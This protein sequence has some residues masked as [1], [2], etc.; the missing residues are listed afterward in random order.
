[1]PKLPRVIKSVIGAISL[2]IIFE[3]LIFRIWSFIGFGIIAFVLTIGFFVWIEKKTILKRE[4]LIKIVLPLILL[5]STVAFIFFEANIYFIHLIIIFSSFCFYLFFSRLKFPLAK[6][7]SVIVTYYWLDLIAFLAAFLSYLFILNLL[8]VKDLPIWFLMIL[9]TLI[10]YLIFSYVLWARSKEGRIVPLFSSLFSLIL[11]ES[12]LAMSF[13]NIDPV[14]KSLL[15]VIVLYF[16]LGV[17]DLKLRG[18][19]TGRKIIEYL[20]TSIIAA[21]LVIITIR[22]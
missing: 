12:F 15:M 2:F 3:L 5:A 18:N 19:L 11:L 22:W 13:W 20:L 7:D 1:M 14:P 8:F 6:E 9:V 16:Y 10:S 21:L 4:S 17:L